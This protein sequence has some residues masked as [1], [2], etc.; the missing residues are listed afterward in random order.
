MA[1]PTGPDTSTR[2]AIPDVLAAR[3][4]SRAMC[5]IWSPEGRI[6]LERELWIAV[7]KAQRE[8]GVAIP[9]EAVIAYEAT[10]GQVNLDSIRQ[11]EQALRHDVKARIEEYCALAGHEYLHMGMTSRDLTDNVEQ[12]QVRLSLELLH[13]KLVTALIRLAERAA[14]H[15][16]TALV[17]RTHHVPAQPTTFGKRLAMFGEELLRARERLGALLESYPLRGMKGAV[18]T[19][20]DQITL[21]GSEDKAM[22]LER[23]IARQLGFARVLDDVGQVYP[24]SLDFEVV[25]ALYQVGAGLS[26][27]AKS[28]RLM[29]GGELVSEGFQDGQVGSSAMPHKVNARSCERING[30]QTV[31]A[32]YLEMTA[33]LAGDQWNEGDISC[34]VVRRVALPSSMFALDGALETFLTVLAEMTAYE[35]AIAAEL[36]RHL[37]FLATTTLLMEALARGGG[38]EELHEVIREH[39]LAVAE[40]LHDGVIARNDLAERLGHDPA[41]PLSHAEIEAILNDPRRFLGAA[42]RQVQAFLDRVASL[43]ERHPRA[44]EYRPE[45]IL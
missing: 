22:R 37:P 1:E 6:V 38:R 26:D 19:Q 43:A 2:P 40:E 13:A 5:G 14:E 45:P 12:L 36:H 25:A 8:L 44:A 34:S 16:E 23:A 7:L 27:F 15:Q 39:S 3:Y 24:R 11:R 17:A 9:P 35:D 31:L 42:A 29:T 30:L 32:G 28:M 4:A 41:F 10:R 18:G 33:R 21:L 20:L